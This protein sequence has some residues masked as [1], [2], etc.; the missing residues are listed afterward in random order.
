MS[1][2]RTARPGQLFEARKITLNGIPEQWDNCDLRIFLPFPD[3]IISFNFIE[4]KVKSQFKIGWISYPSTFHCIKAC[5]H[6]P[7][8]G[9]CPKTGDGF[10]ISLD[11][12][13]GNP[14]NVNL[15]LYSIRDEFWLDHNFDEFP[16]FISYQ[17]F[18]DVVAHM[19][20]F[21]DCSHPSCIIC[22]IKDEKKSIS[23]EILSL[24]NRIENLELERDR[25]DVELTNKR[26]HYNNMH[27]TIKIFNKYS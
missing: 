2:N 26:K 13:F 12:T 15:D 22:E 21:Y 5:S 23:D 1:S 20:Y 24:Q 19:K 18:S 17:V 11:L 3:Q 8:V 25:C 6:S 27:K 14:F 16:R 10:S 7:V 4:S 9:K